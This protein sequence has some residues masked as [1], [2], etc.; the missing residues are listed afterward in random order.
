[1]K[2]TW[3]SVLVVSLVAAFVSFAVAR[4][5]AT[6]AVP[7]LEALQDVEW[8]N[9]TLHLTPAQLKEIGGMQPEFG[10]KLSACCDRH[11]RAR[12]QLL[13]T[14][15]T[16]TNGIA[17][18]RLLVDEMCRAQADSELATL[19]HIQKVYNILTP[20]QQSLYREQLKTM[21]CMECPACTS[22][23]CGRSATDS[24]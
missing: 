11:C 6:P 5:T 8:M 19:E 17:G 16:A 4:R 10:R 9:K 1:M 20:E 15:L 2:H 12:G 24:R 13:G 18:A 3:F 14:L 21:T 22:S 7:R 23:T